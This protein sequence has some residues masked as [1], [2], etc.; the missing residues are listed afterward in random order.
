MLLEDGWEEINNQIKTQFTY[1]ELLQNAKN[2]KIQEIEEYDQSEE[3]NCFYVSG[4]P[5][6]LDKATR[7]VGTSLGRGGFACPMLC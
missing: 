6:W 3:V 2:I 7:A 1:K 4:M 5:I